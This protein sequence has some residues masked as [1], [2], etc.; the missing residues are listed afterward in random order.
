VQD[1]IAIVFDFDD[2]LTPDTSSS[3]LESLGVDV[4]DFWTKRVQRRIDDGWDPVPAYLYEM[5]QISKS[6]NPERLITREK[7]LRFGREVKFYNGATRIFSR[8]K[9]N[10]ESVNPNISVEYYLISS[11][12]GR[13]LQE[14]SI[15]AFEQIWASD[16]SLLTRRH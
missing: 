3:F 13:F 5:I 2:T 14:T 6:G 4:K 16:F 8:L 7:L 15:Q 1:T 10:A 11:A 12:I 9:K